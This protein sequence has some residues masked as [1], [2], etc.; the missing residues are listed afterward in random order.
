MVKLGDTIFVHGG[1]SAETAA[2]PMDAINAEVG[3]ELAK[4]ESNADSILTDELGPLWYRGNVV[5]EAP[6]APAAAPA[7]GVTRRPRACP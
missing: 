3:A 5:R 2:R 1:L 4:G 6:P 7:E